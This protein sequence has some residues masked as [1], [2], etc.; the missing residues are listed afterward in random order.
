MSRGKD[1]LVGSITTKDT[2]SLNISSK[3]KYFG[4]FLKI[5]GNHQNMGRN[6]C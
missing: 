1:L 3:S 4:Y 5:T 6:E 2:F